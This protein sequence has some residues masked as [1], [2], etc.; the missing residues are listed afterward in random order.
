MPAGVYKRKSALGRFNQF[1]D[2]T[3]SCWL[4]KGNIC[5]GYGQMVFNGKHAR[6]HR[7]SWVLHHGEILNGLHVLHKCDVSIC[8]N[9]EHL[10]LGTNLENST[11]R[12]RKGRYGKKLSWGKVELIRKEYLLDRVNMSILAEKNN[13]DRATIH[14]VV[15][16]KI[17]KESRL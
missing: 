12:H 7:V 2:K 3:E 1:I 14:R 9:P 16:N 15:N 11:D 10:F 17:W 4:W 13:V 8:V 6:A 5:A